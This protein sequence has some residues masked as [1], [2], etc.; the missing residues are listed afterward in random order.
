MLA[1]GHNS[2]EIA[3]ILQISQST[4]FRDTEYLRQQAQENLKTHIQHKL[5]EEYQRSLIG[6]NEVLKLSW[7]IANRPNKN[8][9]NNNNDN[10]ETLTLTDDKTRLQALALINDCYKYIMDLTNN[11]VVVIDAIKYLQNKLDHLNSLDK[12]EKELLQ[13]IKEEDKVGQEDIEQPKT[14]NG[15]F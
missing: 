8:N 13:D 6:I 15:I 11:G 5:P 1:K 4:I 2:Y 10:N 12:T 7:Q 14:N 9:A 3:D